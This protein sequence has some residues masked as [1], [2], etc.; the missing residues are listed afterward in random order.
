MTNCTLVTGGSKGIGRAIVER[1]HARDQAVVYLS[2][3]PGEPLDNCTHVATDL[4]N[5]EQTEKHINDVMSSFSISNVICNAGCGQFGSLENFSPKQIKNSIQ[6]NLISPLLIARLLLPTLKTQPRSNL[7]FIGSESGLQG[8]RY[9]SVYSAAKFGLRGAAQA[10]KHEC[11][12]A[13]C[14]VGIVNP[15]M[16]RTD[17]FSS[18]SFEPGKE[19]DMALQAEDVANAV[20]T[21]IDS[22]DHAII[23]EINLSPIKH[24]VTKKP[25]K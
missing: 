23:D 18:L 5:L 6:L 4:N 13:N 14:H 1:L 10:L 20:L 8:G 16:V 17:F 21:L 7:I 9:G 22:P 24:V 15:G 25:Q 11:A 19:A 12:N 3:N 2:R